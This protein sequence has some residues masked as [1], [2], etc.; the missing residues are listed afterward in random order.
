MCTRVN[1][2]LQ[3]HAYART[4]AHTCMRAYV[5]TCVF[6][7]TY[8]CICVFACVYESRPGTSRCLINE[9]ALLYHWPSIPFV[10][11]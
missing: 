9:N 1:A 3:A 11:Q 5:C 6:A 8:A 10:Q 4:S 2:H 7:H